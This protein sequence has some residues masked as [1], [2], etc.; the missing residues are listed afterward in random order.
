MSKVLAI[1]EGRT[2]SDLK[3]VGA[4]A[5]EDLVETVSRR[6]TRRVSPNIETT[7]ETQSP[8]LREHVRDEDDK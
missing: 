3:L 6:L 8:S 2:M 4:S 7:A 1:Y 5:D